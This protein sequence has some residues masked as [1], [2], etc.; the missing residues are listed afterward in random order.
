[1]VCRHAAEVF[2]IH[3]VEGGRGGGAKKG[4]IDQYFVSES[5]IKRESGNG[6]VT[7]VSQML[8]KFETT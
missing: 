3:N 6:L 7:P 4:T 8:A 2:Q 5:C 1:M